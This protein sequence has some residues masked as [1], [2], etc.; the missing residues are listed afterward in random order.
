MK[1]TFLT[2]YLIDAEACITDHRFKGT[3]VGGE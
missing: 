2:D 3:A 1:A